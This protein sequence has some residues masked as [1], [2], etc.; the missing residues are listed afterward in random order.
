MA[1][2]PDSR[3]RVLLYIPCVTLGGTEQ[4]VFRLAT[5]LD[6]RRFEPMV[7]WSA[8]WGMLGEQLLRAGIPVHRIPLKP[9]LTAK[10]IEALRGIR[11]DV[12]HSFNYR[13]G[14]SD[15]LAAAEAGVPAIVSYRG[16]TRFWDPAMR[17]RPSE[18]ARN[19]LAHAFAACCEAV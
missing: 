3:I 19:R 10:A 4:T 2:L 17:V 15:V 18:L 16:N 12:F 6:P 5:G 7:A 9:H 11:P 8:A 14:C 13:D 1:D